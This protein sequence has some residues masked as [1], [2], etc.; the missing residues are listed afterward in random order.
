VSWPPPWLVGRLESKTISMSTTEPDINISGRMRTAPA[1][2]LTRRQKPHKGKKCRK[3]EALSPAVSCLA[4]H[5]SFFCSVNG[6]RRTNMSCCGLCES[7]VF[8]VSNRWLLF[9][10]SFEFQISIKICWDTGR[11]LYVLTSSYR[12]FLC[13]LR[14]RSFRCSEYTSDQSL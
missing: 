2:T 11:S 10:G 4:S 6:Y 12:Q 9:C 8:F 3:Q 14:R 13:R 5:A 7:F 1:I